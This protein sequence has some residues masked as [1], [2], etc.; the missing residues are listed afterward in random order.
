[1]SN[2]QFHARGS[3]GEIWLYDQVGA[4]WFGE[5]ITAK[6]F[7]KE[8]AALGKVST[9]NLHINSPGG[10]VFDGFAIYNQLVQHPARIEVDIDGV[11]A[12]IASVIAMAGDDIRIAKNASL[13]IHNPRGFAAG[14]EAEMQRVAALLRN[15][16]GNLVDTY[17]DRTGNSPDKL[18]AWMDEETWFTAESAVDHGFATAV[19]RETTVAACFGLL[20]DYRRVPDALKK[21]LQLPAADRPQLNLRR[22]RTEAA[23][24]RLATLLA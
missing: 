17:R 6:A 24:H 4:S 5:G 1:M 12:S 15:I 23:A 10:D 3:R 20:N 2:V 22:A 14:D 19:A 7:Q 16:K 13:M 21:Q 18:A 8:L 9:I 11:A